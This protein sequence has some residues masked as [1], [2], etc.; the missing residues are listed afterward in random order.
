MKEK[1]IELSQ[2]PDSYFTKCKIRRMYS[3]EYGMLKLTKSNKI[4]FKS[5]DEGIVKNI[6]ESMF[7]NIY[8]KHNSPIIK[9]KLLKEK[10]IAVKIKKPDQ[11]EHFESYYIIVSQ[12]GNVTLFGKKLNPGEVVLFDH[13]P[14]HIYSNYK[15]FCLD[16]ETED[17]PNFKQ[18][19][20]DIK[21]GIKNN[22]II[23]SNYRQD[24]TDDNEE[25]NDTFITDNLIDNIPKPVTQPKRQVEYA[26]DDTL[27]SGGKYSITQ[28]LF[29]E[30]E[31]GSVIPWGYK[32][33]DEI[34]GEEVNI[35]QDKV[36][37]MAQNKE[38]K[39]VKIISKNGKQFLQGIDFS[40]ANLPQDII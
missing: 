17:T 34:S 39:G 26:D 1:T 2:M 19:V 3:W 15:E 4:I 23:G 33:R 25:N 40:I 5:N 27:Y 13:N 36:L 16:V 31:N 24:I 11:R 38:I 29:K 8:T 37:K 6:D 22:E 20:Q 10:P 7:E 32:L 14:P 35:E 9:S 30:L 28:Q 18:V 12:E 21:N